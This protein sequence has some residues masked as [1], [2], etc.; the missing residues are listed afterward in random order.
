MLMFKDLRL[1][2]LPSASLDNIFSSIGY[3]Y[4]LMFKDLR[5]FRLPS[6]SLDNIFVIHCQIIDI[7]TYLV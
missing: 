4:M 5:L 7:Y 3:K 1:F 6:A 2:R